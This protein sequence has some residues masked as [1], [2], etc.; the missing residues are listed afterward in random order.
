[1][2]Q[3][4]I[5]LILNIDDLHGHSKDI[6]EFLNAVRKNPD[7][8]I[9]KLPELKSLKIPDTDIKA[10]IS[11]LQDYIDSGKKK[12]TLV[13]LEKGYNYATL[14]IENVYDFKN[15]EQIKDGVKE[16]YVTSKYEPETTLMLLLVRGRNHIEEILSSKFA[17]TCSYEKNKS[18]INTLQ[19]YEGLNAF[20]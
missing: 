11:A 8:A 18:I 20:A 3:V 16:W 19:V 15:N 2:I 6:F 12:A 17:M 14:E 10:T 9:R 5:Q 7:V 1:M 4:N 13:W